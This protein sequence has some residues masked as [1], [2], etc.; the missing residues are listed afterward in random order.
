MLANSWIMIIQR[1]RLQ[2]TTDLEK[3][4]EN[5]LMRTGIVEAV[6]VRMMNYKSEIKE[7][8][9]WSDTEKTVY[10]KIADYAGLLERLDVPKPWYI[11]ICLTNA[12]GYWTECFGDESA[13][14]HSNYIQG[15]D[16][17]WLYTYSVKATPTQTNSSQLSAK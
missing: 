11:S 13:E 8:Y 15:V 1:E 3:F 6:D 16:S 5:F 7:A 9:L 4:L 2:T 10:K 17:A 14:L 12:K